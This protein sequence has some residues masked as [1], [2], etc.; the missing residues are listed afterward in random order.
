MVDTDCDSTAHI[1]VAATER[2][3]SAQRLRADAD[4]ACSAHDTRS[5]QC[6]QINHAAASAPA[7]DRVEHERGQADERARRAMTKIGQ[8][9][10]HMATMRSGVRGCSELVG[11]KPCLRWYPNI[12]CTFTK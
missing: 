7:P 1:C 12:R 11:Q 10:S 3:L 4:T 5:Q 9:H 2:T 6:G 8:A